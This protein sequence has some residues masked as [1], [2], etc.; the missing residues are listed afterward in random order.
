MVGV[1][2][3]RSMTA[4]SPGAN[5]SPASAA[6]AAYRRACSASAASAASSV[7]A[8]RA[9]PGQSSALANA[10]LS[11]SLDHHPN[12]LRARCPLEPWRSSIAQ[13]PLRRMQ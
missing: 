1:P 4:Y 7:L 9:H 12:R 10:R 6:T 5:G 8:M 11:V 13:P 2:A 3:K